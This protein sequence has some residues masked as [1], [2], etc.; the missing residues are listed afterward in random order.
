M[1]RPTRRRFLRSA[2]VLGAGLCSGPNGLMAGSAQASVVGADAFGALQPPDP[3]GLMLP[4]EFS[5]RVVAVAER[6]PI[7]SAASAWH[8]APDGGAT[9]A[10]PDGGW[11]YVSN[12]ERSV[13]RGGARALAFNAEGEIIDAYSVLSGTTRNCAGGAGPGGYGGRPRLACSILSHIDRIGPL[14]FDRVRLIRRRWCAP[15][16]QTAVR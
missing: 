15:P 2:A 8:R 6:K 7:P 10:R 3:Q 13:G 9:F 1:T 5:A 4:P 11:V 12:S 16:G 14:G